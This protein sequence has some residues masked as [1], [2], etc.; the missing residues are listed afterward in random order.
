MRCM[1]SFLL[2]SFIPKT[3]K[4]F[5][6][7]IFFHWDILIIKKILLKILLKKKIVICTAT[8]YQKSQ[9]KIIYKVY[10]NKYMFIKILS[11][12]LGFI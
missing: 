5:I 3:V 1:I 7:R 4:K 9:I 12:H 10:I 2:F 11:T 8:S 6:E